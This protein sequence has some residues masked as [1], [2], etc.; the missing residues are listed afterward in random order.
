[1]FKVLAPIGRA[2]RAFFKSDVQ[3][4][5]DDSGL[6]LVLADEPPPARRARAASRKDTSANKEHAEL[7]RMRLA[8]AALLDQMPE[9]RRVLR[10]LVFIEHA[11][12]KKGLRALHKVP[13]EVLERALEQFEGVVINWSDEGLACLRSKMAVALMDREPDHGGADSD[14]VMPDAE[15]EE[16]EEPTH[17]E[18]LE[19]DA[20]DA[21]EA[22]LRAAYGSMALPGLELQAAAACDSTPVVVE[23]HGELNSPSAKALAKSAKS[24][25]REKVDLSLRQIHEA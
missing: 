2:V 22:A 25:P 5:R 11:L 16:E 17:C 10:H 12:L 7:S 21:A 24:A 18:A 20:A 14:L 6:H 15:V 13:Y 3:L 1:M 8:L 9:H 19:G 23:Y 4:K